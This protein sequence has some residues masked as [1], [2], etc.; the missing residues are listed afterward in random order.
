MP[1]GRLEIRPHRLAAGL[2]VDPD[3]PRRLAIADRGRK[4][5]EAEQLVER[6]LRHSVGAKTPHVAPPG[7]EFAEFGLKV[8]V[9]PPRLDGGLRQILHRAP[10]HVRH[11]AEGVRFA[12]KM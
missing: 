1:V 2:V 5:G 9:E 12:K 8:R 3:E 11:S 6:H 7:D 10:P 4:R